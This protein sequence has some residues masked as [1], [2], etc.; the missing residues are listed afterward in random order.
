MAMKGTGV[1]VGLGLGIEVAVKV[2]VGM[3]VDV[4]VGVSLGVKVAVEVAVPAL[5]KDT[6]SQKVIVPVWLTL[7]TKRTAM[8]C[9]VEG[10]VHESDSC[11]H[12]DSG[13]LS[14]GESTI[15][16]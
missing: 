11:S 8:H 13:P 10:A 1:G 15:P 3:D 2:G 4:G 5:D 12:V 16:A 14:A 7:V 9:A 6:S